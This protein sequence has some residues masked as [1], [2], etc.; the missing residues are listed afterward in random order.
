MANVKLLFCGSEH[1]G[2][3]QSTV[4]CYY[5]TGNEVSI[6]IEDTDTK[7]FEVI[8]LDRETAIKFSKELRKQ[9]ALISPDP[10]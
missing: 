2:T 1:T 10:F 9:I 3:K 7:T 6:I 5:N 4:E 8:S